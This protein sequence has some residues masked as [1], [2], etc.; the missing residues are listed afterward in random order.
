MA[1]GA[2]AEVLFTG[3]TVVIEWDTG[4]VL[5]DKPVLYRQ[6]LRVDPTV[7]DQEAYD[8]AYNLATLTNY[9]IDSI[10]L[11]SENE[12]GPIA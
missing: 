1:L 10:S 5:E 12:L 4:E 6:S 7:T 2:T 9:T 3:K 8:I 11:V